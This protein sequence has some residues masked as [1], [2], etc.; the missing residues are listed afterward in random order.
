MKGGLRFKMTKQK[1]IKEIIEKRDDLFKEFID[2]TEKNLNK[3]NVGDLIKTL[4]FLK[5]VMVVEV[6]TI[7]NAKNLICDSCE[8]CKNKI[9]RAEKINKENNVLMRIDEMGR[10][11]IIGIC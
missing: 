6:M 5:K 9:A 4:D 1:I 2:Y 7:E 3:C 10:Y 8:D 11:H